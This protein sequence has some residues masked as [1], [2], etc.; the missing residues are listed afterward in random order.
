MKDQDPHSVFHPDSKY[1]LTT[2]MMQV[3]SITFGNSVLH[4]NIE[5][6]IGKMFLS[7]DISFWSDITP[8][9]KNYK[10]RYVMAS[11]IM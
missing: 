5:H 3:S 8:C 4:K 7:H 6:D 11:I 9:N 10:P 2:G 1:M